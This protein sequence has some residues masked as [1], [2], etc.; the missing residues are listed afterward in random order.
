MTHK[1]RIYRAHHI[2]RVRIQAAKILSDNFP[3]WDVRPEDISPATGS[4]RTDWRNDVYRWELF[5]RLKKRANS[6]DYMPVA[7]GCWDTL[8]RFVKLASKNGCSVD[9]DG[10][11]SPNE[12]KK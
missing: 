7:C 3:D 2:G 12:G 6:G 9:D 4:W 1:R 8:T 10:V 5:T 11:I